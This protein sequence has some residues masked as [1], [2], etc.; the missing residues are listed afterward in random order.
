MLLAIREKVTG[1]VALVFVGV[2]ALFMVVPMLYQ[3][4]SGFGNNDAVE[5]N[6]DAV[7]LQSYNARLSAN[8]QRLAQAFGGKI[9]EY[10]DQNQFLVKQTI[11]EI[12]Q[13]KLLTQATIEDGYRVSGAD[14]IGLI[15]EIPEFQKDGTFDRETYERQLQSRGYSERLFEVDF[16]RQ[17]LQGQLQQGVVSSAFVSQQQLD[18][19]A[20]LQYQSRD[21]S[22]VTLSLEDFRAKQSVGKDEIESY[23]NENTAQFQHPEKVAL[24]YVVF[25]L[26]DYVQKVD[27]PAKDV[28]QEYNTGIEAGRYVIPEMRKASHILLELEEDASEADAQK[29]LDAANALVERLKQGEDFAALAKKESADPGSAAQ[30]GD[31]GEIKPGQMVAPFEAAVYAQAQ[32]EIGEP[33][34]T[35]FGYHIIRVDEVREERTQSLADVRDSILA[36]L[37]NNRAKAKFDADLDEASNLAFENPDSLQPLVEELSLIVESTPKFTRG[38]G[39]GI[40]TDTAVRDTAFSAEVLQEGNNSNPIDLANGE[41]VIVR[42]K[43]HEPARDKTLDEASAEIESVLLSEKAAKALQEAAQSFEKALRDG[44]ALKAL[45]KQYKV[46]VESAKAVTRNEKQG[47]N[48]ALVQKLF[49]IPAP[50][51]GE[52]SYAVANLGSDRAVL[53]LSAVKAGDYASLEAAEQDRLKEQ[54]RG[55]QGNGDYQALVQGLRNAADVV[56]NPQLQGE[57]E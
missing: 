39:E 23:Y 28:E 51:E 8:Q 17:Y 6:G 41:T 45:A 5:V 35:R 18:A 21:V 24:D 55:A 11:D 32:G 2:I 13:D 48:D 49:T 34:K 15:K 43:E 3:Y 37:K 10:F 25:N 26:D 56:I 47:L 44:E 46:S 7:T 12:V 30:G 52:S 1:V 19:A 57:E 31:L 14:V 33:V 50:K 38:S 27:V 4:V 53:V 29:V 40:A 9:P 16:S 42:V 36:E 54:L 22:Y 20:Q